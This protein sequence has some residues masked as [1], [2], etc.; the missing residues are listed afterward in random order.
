MVGPEPL[1]G[2]KAASVWSGLLGKEVRYGGEAL[3]SWEVAMRKDAPAWMAFDMRM[4]FQGYLERGFASGEG[5]FDGLTALLG[6]PLRRDVVAPLW[7]ARTVEGV[8]FGSVSSEIGGDSP[9]A[10]QQRQGMQLM[11]G[12]PKVDVF[13]GKSEGNAVWLD[14]KMCSP[15]AFYQFWLNTADADVVDRLKV[16]TFLT[17]AEIEE[18]LGGEQMMLD[19]VFEA[20]IADVLDEY[21]DDQR[22]K[23]ALF[24]QGVI[25]AYGGPKDHGTASIKLM[26]YQG[27]LEGQGPVWGYVKGGM[28]MISFAIADAAQEAGAV[29]AAGVPVA[30]VMPGE[31]VVLEAPPLRLGVPA[32]LRVDGV[33]QAEALVAQLG[34]ELG[35]RVFVRPVGGADRFEEREG[36]EGV[37]RGGHRGVAGGRGGSRARRPRRGA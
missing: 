9:A 35:V 12:A 34:H 11:Y 1:S 14:A 3:D 25:A 6:H 32:D 8:S 16:F 4:M 37:D 13:I 24:G 2:P 22:L 5:D 30:Q 17:R 33:A 19:I 18:L 7:H 21:L 10:N 20:S 15:Y 36:E 26:H 27:D 23:D 29:L 31:G 28:G